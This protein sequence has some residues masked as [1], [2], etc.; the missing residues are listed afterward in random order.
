MRFFVNLFVAAIAAFFG[1]GAVYPI[2]RV[3]SR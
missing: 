3:M 2:C 1:V